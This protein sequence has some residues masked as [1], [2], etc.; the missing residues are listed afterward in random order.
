LRLDRDLTLYS[1]TKPC[2]N[3][4]FREKLSF[5]PNKP[6]KLFNI[7]G[8]S[9][10]YRIFLEKF[11]EQSRELD[12]VKSFIDRL[13]ILYDYNKSN[14]SPCEK[15]DPAHPPLHNSSQSLHKKIACYKHQTT[16]PN[17]GEKNYSDE[18]IH[19]FTLEEIHTK[20]PMS[21]QRLHD[22]SIFK[23]QSWLYKANSPMARI[24]PC[25]TT[26]SSQALS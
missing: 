4:S 9:T 24:E 11:K 3:N 26:F 19:R 18:S 2:P 12:S 15:S 6:E 10:N 7:H 16:M 17:R 23:S 14:L 5:L 13:L 8:L 22:H 1:E 20:I 25:P 21:T